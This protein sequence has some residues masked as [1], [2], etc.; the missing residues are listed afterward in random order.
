MFG[1][2]KLSCC[3]IEQRNITGP[4]FPRLNDFVGQGIEPFSSDVLTPKNEIIASCSFVFSSLSG[5]KNITS[6]FEPLRLEDAKYHEG[7][8]SIHKEGFK[9]IAPDLLRKILYNLGDTAVTT[10]A[11]FY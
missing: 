4:S 5:S 6:F 3:T 2:C 7:S 11:V 1:D 10:V 8:V 9:N